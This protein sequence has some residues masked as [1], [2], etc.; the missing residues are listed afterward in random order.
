MVEGLLVLVAV[1]VALVVVLQLLAIG[2]RGTA[3]DLSGIASRL[4]AVDRGQEK[5]E[6]AIR[7]ELARNRGEDTQRDKGLR[8]ELAN[9]MNR[10]LV[11][12]NSHL[13]QV[14]KGLGEM[15]TL[16][17]GVGDLKQLLTNVR[18]RGTW[19]EMQLANLLQDMLSPGQYATNVATRPGETEEVE[20]AI[21][22]PGS[23][24]D[25]SNPVWLPIDAKFPTEDYRR[26]QDAYES[27][28]QAALGEARKA[29]TKTIKGSAKKIQEKYVEPPHTTDFAIMYLATEGLYSEALRLPSLAEEIQRDYRVAIAGPMTLAALLNA[30]QMGFRTLAIEKRSTEIIVT[31]GAIKTQFKK[32]AESLD[33]IRKKIDDAG[34]LLHELVTTRTKAITRRLRDVEELPEHEAQAVLGTVDDLGDDDP[35][36]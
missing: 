3:P 4:E 13:E 12:V 15:Q 29:L 23:K 17:T 8:E 30:L 2:R 7:D 26:L 24:D 31:L 9:S 11:Q 36:T 5:T 34:V 14:S 27:G 35:V 6:K 20:F 21:R 10:V 32:F 18:N 19:G 25:A 1:L 22:L 33:K 16:A 28:D